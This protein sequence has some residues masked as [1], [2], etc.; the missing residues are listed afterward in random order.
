MAPTVRTGPS[1]QH[2]KETGFHTACR[3]ENIMF[4]DRT[5]TSA[6]KLTDFGLAAMFVD[7]TPLSEVSATQTTTQ[8]IQFV[9]C[10][11]H[12]DMDNVYPGTS[13]HFG[14]LRSKLYYRTLFRLRK[15]YASYFSQGIHH[16][17]YQLSAINNVLPSAGVGLSLL[18]RS[19]GSQVRQQIAY[20]SHI[21]KATEQST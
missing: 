17:Y 12:A 10:S 13:G 20:P 9:S 6:V 15:V 8:C 3:P 1:K 14:A 4:V 2:K 19:R 11:A 16:M 21:Y 7:G 5:D 18:C